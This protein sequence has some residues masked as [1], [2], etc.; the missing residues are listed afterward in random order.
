MLSSGKVF[1]DDTTLPVLD[2]GGGRNKT[3]RLWCYAVDDRPW[4]GPFHPAAAYVYSEDRRGIRPAGHLA[5]FQGV[6]EVD[7][8]AGFKRLADDRASAPCDWLSAACT[9]G[10]PS[11]SFTS[12]PDRRSRPSC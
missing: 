7:G 4:C 2:P 6:L 3:G 1:A 11:T 5:S 8:H 12:L 9:C 10:V